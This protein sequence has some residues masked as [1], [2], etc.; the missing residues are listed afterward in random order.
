MEKSRAKSSRTVLLVKLTTLF[1]FLLASSFVALLAD[2][3]TDCVER[4]PSEFKQFVTALKKAESASKNGDKNLENIHLQEAKSAL[5]KLPRNTANGVLRIEF[6]KALTENTFSR[7]HGG[8]SSQLSDLYQGLAICAKG[9]LYEHLYEAITSHESRMPY[10]ASVTDGKS[11]PIFKKIAFMQRMNLPIAWYIDVQARKFQKNGIPIIIGDLKSMSTIPS[12]ETKPKYHGTFN[13]QILGDIRTH[14]RDYQKKAL[15]FVKD[16][17]FA[18]V[19]AE[20]L[21]MVN[22]VRHMEKQHQAH[23]AMTVHMLDSV[24]YTALHA[25]KYQ[26][27]SQGKTDNLSRQFLTIQI[28]P[29]QECLPTDKNAQALHGLGAGV[30]V[31]DV[32]DIPFLQEWQLSHK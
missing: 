16:A 21:K 17:K 1:F 9:G 30:I 14:L 26:A 5:E 22:Y 11:D 19:A 28:L 13:S 12:K 23:M 10:Y 24:G 27:D 3:M 18:E 4:T 29:L 2:E 15:K 20:T 25:A 6:Q 8:K 32:P 7:I 31:N